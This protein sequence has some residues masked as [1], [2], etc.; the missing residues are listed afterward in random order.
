MAASVAAL[1]VAVA[2]A[3]ALAMEWFQA[4]ISEATWSW[5]S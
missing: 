4:I 3:L 5:L 1:A 2:L